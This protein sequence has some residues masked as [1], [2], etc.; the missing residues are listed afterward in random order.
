MPGGSLPEVG[1]PFI[2]KCWGC[3]GAGRQWASRTASLHPQRHFFWVG[4]K[5]DPDQF[6]WAGILLPNLWL[7]VV[8]KLQK[9]RRRHPEAHLYG[10]VACFRGPFWQK[11]RQMRSKRTIFCGKLPCGV[12]AWTPRDKKMH[13]SG[14][15]G[16]EQPVP[17]CWRETGH[18]PEKRWAKRA[19]GLR[20]PL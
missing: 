2:Q 20:F 4:A 17:R 1:G 10:A 7:W 12:P 9:H 16:K 8:P 19:L 11:W 6:C 18:L 15:R 5:I 14:A 3:S 13:P